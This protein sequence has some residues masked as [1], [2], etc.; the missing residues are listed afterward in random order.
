LFSLYLS[1]WSATVAATVLGG[2]IFRHEAHK[3]SL[4]IC[5]FLVRCQ[6]AVLY[7]LDLSFLPDCFALVA[8]GIQGN[9]FLFG[10]YGIVI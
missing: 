1:I 6:A 9:G 8:L 7:S 5:A 10:M 2:F 4:S 3:G